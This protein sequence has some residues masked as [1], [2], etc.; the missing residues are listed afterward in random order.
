MATRAS[1][2]RPLVS[3]LAPLAVVPLGL[4]QGEPGLYAPA[5]P[6]DSAFLRVM[7][8]DS[9]SSEGS[10]GDTAFE[11]SVDD[12]VTP[13]RVLPEGVVDV[14]IGTVDGSIDVAPGRFYTFAIID[15]RS[16]LFEDR[17]VENRAKAVL[18]LYNF[19]KEPLSMTTLDA[20]VEL[21]D[22]IAVRASASIAVNPV[23]VQFVVWH[24]TEDLATVDDVRL[25]RGRGYFV[26]AIQ[27]DDYV[28]IH[29]GH[30]ITAT[31]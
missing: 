25:S 28:Q 6:D 15:G 3:L 29:H 1:I 20:S 17:T 9:A 22:N 23:D 16:I 4:S 24:G 5:P 26:L 18:T 14:S 30:A 10:V 21:F 7:S 13:Y 31:D 8:I 2:I 19:T 12:P 27:R 11:L